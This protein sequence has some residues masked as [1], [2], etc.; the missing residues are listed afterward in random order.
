MEYQHLAVRPQNRLNGAGAIVADGSVPLA[1]KYI[2]DLASATVTVVAATGITLKHGTAGAEAVDTTIG[3]SA[4]GVV[5][6]ATDTT[7]GAVVDRINKSPNWR[8]EIIDGLR[9]DVVSGSQLKA[10]SEYTF[11]PKR[12]VKGLLCDTSVALY[13]TY[14]ISARRQNWNRSQAGK[15]SAFIQA[16]ALVDVGSGTLTL[17]ISN[18]NAKSS[19]ATTLG[20]FAGTDNT[21]LDTEAGNGTPSVPVFLSEIGDDILVRYTGSVDLPDTGAYLR[22]K[23]FIEQ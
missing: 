21:A 9:S 18:V 23:G 4:N 8:A 2:G 6:F 20:V 16:Y 7:L 13:I 12:E 3:A 11:S 22:V 1:V 5:D 19:V 17:T 10:L 15:R 14:R